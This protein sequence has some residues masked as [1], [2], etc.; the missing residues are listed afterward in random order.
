M[1]DE[2]ALSELWRLSLEPKT[3]LELFD[4]RNIVPRICVFDILS[5]QRLGVFV[6]CLIFICREAFGIKGDFEQEFL[7]IAV[8]G[9][10]A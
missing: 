4:H 10:A 6:I 3:H 2:G 5:N 8:L 7:K 9:L 1:L